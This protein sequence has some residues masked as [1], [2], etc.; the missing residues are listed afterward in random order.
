LL[1]ASALMAGIDGKE[2]H[3][4]PIDDALDEAEAAVQTG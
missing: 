4:C 1:A 3:E 2:Q